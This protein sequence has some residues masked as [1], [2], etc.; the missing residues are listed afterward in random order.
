M[1]RRIGGDKAL[2]EMQ[3]SLGQVMSQAASWIGQFLTSVWSS[4]AAVVGIM[5]LIVVT[6]VVA[7]YLLIDWDRMIATVDGWVPPRHRGTVRMLAHEIDSAIAGF[8]RGQALVC[9]TLGTFYAT[10]LSLAGLNFGV[11]IGLGS[12]LL[13]FIPYVGSL[14]GFVVSLGVAIVQF[15]PDWTMILVIAAIYLVGQFVEGNI[16]SPLLVGDAVGLHPV[17]LMFA[18]FAF[19]SLFGFVGVLLAVPLAAGGRRADPL[20]PA[21]VSQ[22]SVLRRP[23]G[24]RV[25]GSGR[26]RRSG[27]VGAGAPGSA[28]GR[29]CTPADSA[30]AGGGSLRCRCFR[31]RRGQRPGVRSRVAVAGVARAGVAPDRACGGSA[32]ATWPPF[33]PDAR[34]PARLAGPELDAEAV[35]A[36]DAGRPLVVDPCDRGLADEHALFHLLNRVRAER[37]SALLV[38]RRAPQHWG[39]STPDLV[40]RLRLSPVVEIGPPDDALFRAILAK[41][42]NDRQLAVDASVIDYLALRLDR[43]VDRARDVVARLDSEALSMARRM[44]R[45]MVAGVLQDVIETAARDAGG[46]DDE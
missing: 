17:W 28:D 34:A 40:S 19:G 9:L 10:A 15:W 12:G 46:E 27:G 5:S 45:A 2:A 13:T 11:L 42:F 22:Q 16:L 29:R 7:F 35:L 26:V 39:L 32:R 4:G 24:A 3:S 37:G 21:P 23:V 31:A 38:G 43:S 6:P 1:L 30:M 14:T 44:T 18:L 25:Q 36:L 8:I 33:S 41:L 20:R